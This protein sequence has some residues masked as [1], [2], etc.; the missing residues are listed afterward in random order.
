MRYFLLFMSSESIAIA[1][2]DT[3]AQR[4]AFDFIREGEVGHE[5]H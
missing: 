1:C 3:F 5:G 4:K 2:D